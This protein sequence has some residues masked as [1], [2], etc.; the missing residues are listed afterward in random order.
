MKITLNEKRIRMYI[1]NTTDSKNLKHLSVA[2]MEV[3]HLD[4]CLRKNHY[5]VCQECSQQTVPKYQCWISLSFQTQGTFFQGSSQS[6]SEYDGKIWDLAISA[7]CGAPLTSENCL[8]RAS[9]QGWVTVHHY[10][11]PSLSSS[12]CLLF[13]HWCQ[14]W[15]K[16][17]CMGDSNGKVSVCIAGD[18]SSIP[19]SERSPGEGNGHPLQYFCLENPQTENPWDHKASDMTEQLTLSLSGYRVYE[20]PQEKESQFKFLE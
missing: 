10:L 8:L 15:E 9:H 16:T 17:L 14:W 12:C 20:K 5:S 2:A 13:F 4:L 3:C 1:Y 11:R 6:K 19:R 7:H 18:P